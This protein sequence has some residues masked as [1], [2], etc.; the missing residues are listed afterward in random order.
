MDN[1]LK[2]FIANMGMLC[3]TWTVVYNS[4]IS[5]GMSAKDALTHTQAFMSS[6]M[7]S[8]PQIGGGKE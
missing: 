6:F 4:F 7:A 1:K 3:E 8:I 2:N 5:Q